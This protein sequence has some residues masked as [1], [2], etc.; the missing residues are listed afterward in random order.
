M[1]QEPSAV[2]TS[3]G[4]ALYRRRNMRLKWDRSE[5]PE[6]NAIEVMGRPTFRR[7]VNMRWANFRRHAS[8]YSEKV[9]PSVSKSLWI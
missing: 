1:G 4:V 5:K 3:V 8:T 2:R 9:A 6:S 7:S